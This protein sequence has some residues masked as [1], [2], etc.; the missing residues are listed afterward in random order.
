M[1]LDVG[2]DTQRAI[3]GEAARAGL[4]VDA[5]LHQVMLADSLRRHTAWSAANPGLDE[6][7]AREAEAAQAAADRSR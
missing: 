5:Y 1:S 2:H 3:E 4:S 7:A 6:W